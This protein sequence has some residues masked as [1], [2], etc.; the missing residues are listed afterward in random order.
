VIEKMSALIHQKIQEARLLLTESQ[1]EETEGA[2]IQARIGELQRDLERLS[3]SAREKRVIGNSQLDASEALAKEYAIASGEL[4]VEPVAAA[5]PAKKRGG[6]PKAATTVA[7]VAAP[8]AAAA[9]AQAKAKG[10]AKVAKEPKPAKETIK[11][12]EPKPAKEAKPAKEKKAKPVAAAAPKVARATGEKGPPLH[13]KIKIVMGSKEMTIPEVIEALKAHDKSW[14]PKSQDL[15]AY[16][17]LVL[18]THLV[19]HFDRV[20]RGVYKVKKAG[21]AAAAAPEKTPPP[22][23]PSGNGGGNGSGNGPGLAKTRG[24]RDN[25]ATSNGASSKGIDELGT[26]V[27][28]SPF[29]GEAA[30]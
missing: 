18:S 27:M 13:E 3:K 26:N 16:I 2:V 29:S 1:K 14:V 25:H 19:D 28:E 23:G 24:K 22:S 7:P 5:A 4:K 30:A 8:T 12:K 20:K 21:G 10:K 15:G 9:P 17:S 11:A 6:R